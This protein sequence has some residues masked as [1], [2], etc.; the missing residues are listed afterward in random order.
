[1]T[2]SLRAGQPRPRSIASH[3][4]RSTRLNCANCA[5]RCARLLK[6]KRNGQPP[7]ASGP[8]SRLAWS[9]RCAT[10]SRHPRPCSPSTPCSTRSARSQRRT[11]EPASAQVVTPHP[12]SA[13]ARRLKDDRGLSWFETLAQEAPPH[14]EGDVYSCGCAGAATPPVRHQSFASWSLRRPAAVS[15]H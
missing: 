8:T 7:Q 6:G 15:P 1:M 4:G 10:T 14:H 12:G 2:S 9:E 5:R 13:E 3:D 11:K